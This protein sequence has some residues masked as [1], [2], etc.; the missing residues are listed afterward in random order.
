MAVTKSLS[1]RDQDGQPLQLQSVYWIHT[2]D[3]MDSNQSLLGRETI[4]LSVDKTVLD[5][6]Y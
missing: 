6:Q 1:F 3:K 4:E 2:A 5:L